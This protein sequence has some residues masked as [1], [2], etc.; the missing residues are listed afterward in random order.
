MCINMYTKMIILCSQAY[1][2]ND[3][4]NT[5]TVASERICMGQRQAIQS[6]PSLGRII[7]LR[8]ENT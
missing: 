1:T 5:V 4:P 7:A 6:S 2:Q 8:P 3:I